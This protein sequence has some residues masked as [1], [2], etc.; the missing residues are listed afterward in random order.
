MSFSADL[1]IE[2]DS[3]AHKIDPRIKVIYVGLGIVAILLLQNIFVLILILLLVQGLI[4][5]ARVPKDRILWVW[6]RMLPINILIPTLFVIF[7][8]QG[9]VLFEF[10][11]LKFTVLALVR[12]VALALRLDAIAFLVFSWIFTTDQTKI[13][14]SLVK[15]GVPF[16]GGLMLAIGL[17]YIPTFYGTFA[18]VSE[19][20]QARALDLSKGNFFERLRQYIPIL[21][22]MVISALRT[23]DALSKALESRALGLRDV[24]RT[25]MH[26]IAFRRVD[27]V[28]LALVLL[29]FAVAV[30]L[31][32]ALGVGADLI[33]LL[34]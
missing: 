14:R 13:V 34:P 11:F 24:Q 8:P 20:Q 6:K 17:R 9:P 33:D 16:N 28:Y 10:L 27:Y 4:L 29:G 30:Y 21:V 3:W 2:R 25:C 22:A 15:L 7:Y 18:A 5:L 23:A 19:A 1:Y 32:F 31:R 26:E 12:G